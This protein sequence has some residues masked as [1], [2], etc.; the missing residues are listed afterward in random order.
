MPR[1]R[2]QHPRQDMRPCVNPHA[3]GLD[4]GS[5]EIWACVPE[6][7]DAEPVRSFE[8]FTPDLLA[9]ADWLAGCRIDTVAM[10]STG[11]YWIPVY[12]ILEARGFK[13]YLVNAHHLKHVP[14]RK[15]DSKDCQ[16]I[17]Y[18]HTCGLLS[19]SFRPEGSLAPHVRNFTLT[20][21]TSL[22]CQNY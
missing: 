9:L 15:S 6:D 10:E 19:A 3:A 14:G 1:R 11:V 2:S 7:R 13:V 17:Q 8:T 18:L 16:W 12:E 4:I 20:R 5:G 22:R 21:V